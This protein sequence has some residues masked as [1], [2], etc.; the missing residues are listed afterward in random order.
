MA[1]GSNTPRGRGRGRRTSSETP[2]G[3]SLPR[4]PGRLSTGE[5][6]EG[7]R[8]RAGRSRNNE[9]DPSE[10]PGWPGDVGSNAPASAEGGTRGSDPGPARGDGASS[11]VR[12]AAGSTSREPSTSRVGPSSSGPASPPVPRDAP[13]HGARGTPFN[14]LDVTPDTFAM[15]GRYEHRGGLGDTL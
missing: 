8:N 15:P 1:R 7:L 3:P 10:D 12:S 6:I 9:P 4:V 2:S 5:T 11:S 14:S 13:R